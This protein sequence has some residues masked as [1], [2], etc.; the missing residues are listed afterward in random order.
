VN[1][2]AVRDALLPLRGARHDYDALLDLVGDARVIALGEASHG[3]DEFYRERARVTQRLIDEC[4]F[5]AVAV[6]ADWP[7]AARVNR[8]VRGAN[9]ARDARDALADFRRFPAWMWRNT[10][11]VDFVDWLRRRNVG[12]PDS[13]RAGFYGLDLYSLH[14]SMDAVV[15]YL[16]RVDPEAAR[17]ARG[18]YACFDHY[19]GDVERYGYAAAFGAGDDC[20]QEVVAQ[21]IDLRRPRCGTW[22]RTARS[23]RTSSFSPSRTRVWWPTPR[24]TTARCSAA[25]WS[26]GTCATPT[27]PTRSTRSWPTSVVASWSGRTTHTSATR[28]QPNW[29]RSA[30]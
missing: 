19:G 16:E 15:R 9:E 20:E 13:R 7:D 4:G 28:G 21:L 11:V 27:W 30:S 6:E 1:R 18:R 23:P 22:R 5:S 24:P 17:R 12:V 8:F 25:A 29:E 3:T 14:A 2:D 26:R 10:A